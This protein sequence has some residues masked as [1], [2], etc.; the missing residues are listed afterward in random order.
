[1]SANPPRCWCSPNRRPGPRNR[2]PPAEPA[3]PRCPVSAPITW[4]DRPVILGYLLALLGATGSGL[5]S[6][7]ESLGVRRAGAYGGG[8]DDLGRV[9]RQPVYW[10]GLVV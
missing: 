1:M 9:A 6:V 10:S 7:L 4:Q 2:Y 3:D 5:G 8:A